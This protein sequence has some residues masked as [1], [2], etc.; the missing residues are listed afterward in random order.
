M[1]DKDTTDA[2]QDARTQ[3]AD[4]WATEALAA[5]LG[6]VRAVCITEYQWL[7]DELQKAQ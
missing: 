4:A 3:E 5:M 7:I 2:A 6:R 1:S